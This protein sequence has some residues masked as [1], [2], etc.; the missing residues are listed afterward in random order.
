M[1]I[2]APIERGG[3][4]YV[5]GT[6]FAAAYVSAIAALLLERDPSLDARSILKLL[7]TGAEDLG[8]AGRDDDF[9]AGRVN[10]YSSLKLLTNQ[11]SAKGR[12]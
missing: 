6:S 2:L 3:Y 4:A 5:S 11:L 7:A 9:G 1:D 8:P 12:D 10:A